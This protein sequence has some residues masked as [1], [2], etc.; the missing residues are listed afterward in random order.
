MITVY[1]QFITLVIHHITAD[2]DEDYEWKRRQWEQRNRTF[3][4]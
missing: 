4:D 2:E 3:T 1:I